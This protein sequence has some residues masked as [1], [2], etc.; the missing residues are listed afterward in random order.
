MNSWTIV[1]LASAV[2]PDTALA[3]A[4][5]QDSLKDAPK[6]PP[7]QQPPSAPPGGMQNRV[8]LW[9]DFTYPQQ[10]PFNQVWYPPGQQSAPGMAYQQSQVT[11]AGTIRFEQ[12]AQ[13]NDLP[14]PLAMNLDFQGTH[15]TLK[16]LTPQ[17]VMPTTSTTTTS[18]TSSIPIQP[19]SAQKSPMVSRK[20]ATFLG[21]GS[22]GGSG[23]GSA[24][25]SGPLYGPEL[26]YDLPGSL[27]D[28][29]PFDASVQV[30]ARALFGSM[31]I[32]GESSSAQD[33]SVG[34]RLFVP[35]WSPPDFVTGPYLTLGPSYLTTHFGHA[36]G[37]DLGAGWSATYRVI[38]SV[39]VTGQIGI[40]TFNGS[41]LF[42]WGVAGSLGLSIGF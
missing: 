22:G 1:V 39:Y 40:D 11:F 14:F 41:N 24:S 16:G 15:S 23:S 4:S 9:F 5:A 31:T 33:Y 32:E 37:F 25:G 12:G 38:R 20:S 30:Y 10:N 28:W 29:M 21:L 17:T 3:Q 42:R 35:V 27:S 36:T 8:N 26:D 7:Q 6:G 34:L 13:A 2:M 18:S 19:S